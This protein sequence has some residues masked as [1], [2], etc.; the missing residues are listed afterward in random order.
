MCSNLEAL[1]ESLATYASGFDA[2]ALTPAQAGVV[3][4]HCCGIEASVAAM[5]AL[6]AARAAEGSAWRDKG[7]R[8]PADEL[9]H[10]AGMSPTSAKRALDA[11]R[12]LHVQPDVAK[13]A[14]GGQLSS[15]QA[16][17]VS[18]GVAVN[19]TKV[20]ELLD[21]ARTG[22]IPELNGHV[23][24]IKAG[25]TDPEER[26]RRIHAR[27]HLRRWTD[28]EG[29]FQ[30]HLYGHVEDG[31][32]IW[33]VLDPI[34][35]R[36]N[37]LRAEGDGRAEG[38]GRDGRAEGAGRAKSDGRAEGDG[39]SDAH[40]RAEGDGRDS[41]EALAYDALVLFAGIAAGQDG[42]LDL[43]DL[44]GLGLFPQLEAELLD[45]L[46]RRGRDEPGDEQGAGPG[47]A[48]RFDL[49]VRGETADPERYP[50]DEG[51]R[52]ESAAPCADRHDATDPGAASKGTTN[53]DRTHDHDHDHE[54][55]H[56]DPGGDRARAPIGPDAARA[57]PA[58]PNVA[59]ADR[60]STP[61]RRRKLAGSPTKIMVRVDLDALLRGVAIDGELCELAGYGP[62][63]VSVVKRLAAE[64]NA[65]LVGVL[66]KSQQVVGIYHHRRRPSAHQISA[67]EF[68]Y[69]SCAVAGCSARAGLQMDHREDWVRTHFTVL[70][71]LDCLCPH[72]HRLKTDHGWALVAGVGKR[73]FVPPSDRRHPRC[74]AGDR[75]DDP[76]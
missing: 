36:L 3:V 44:L 53:V 16:A 51:A 68:L 74:A 76:P 39:R 13:A 63:P 23:A 40:G 12:R 17:I 10:E 57:A 22:S 25:A 41:M 18:E 6:A 4:R 1:R 72:H 61:R 30:A 31:A 38:G 50:H 34:L 8:S 9:A 46:H 2:A 32:T 29:A 27:R 15:E 71:L 70:D 56:G 52:R 24:R 5:K 42:E 54:H 21:A 28:L 75:A 67:L 55:E 48:L 65:F 19:P 26:R 37:A 58:R 7:F 11:G 20:G 73:A 14:L 64:D 62:V 59:G 66:T 35:R 33:R 45:N 43:E 47:S 60:R 69:P 49:D